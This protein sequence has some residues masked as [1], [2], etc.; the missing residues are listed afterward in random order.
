IGGEG[1][2][3]GGDGSGEDEG[4]VDA[5][6]AAEDEFSE[7]SGAD[8]GG[9]RRHAYTCNGGGPQSGEDDAGGEGQ[10]DFEEALPAGHAEG[11]GDV[12]ER[13]VDGADAGVGVAQDGQQGV[14]GEGEDGEARGVFAEPWHGEEQ[15]EEGERGDGL[16]DVGEGDD[17]AGEGFMAG[18]EDAERQGNSSC[19]QHREKR[20]PEMLEGEA[21]DL[22]GVGGE[23]GHDWGLGTRD[24]GPG[25]VLRWTART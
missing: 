19:D 20:E 7:A 2:E 9:D 25:A 18:E 13:G 1:E 15:A 10:F 14:A 5:G 11:A 22:V 6:D 23:E 4:V 21:G 17:G 3:G 24:W 12:L 16:D 8:G